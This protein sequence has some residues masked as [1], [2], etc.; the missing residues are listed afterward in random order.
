MVHKVTERDWVGTVV[1]E[2][3][4]TKSTNY[5][6]ISRVSDRLALRLLNMIRLS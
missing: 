3:F 1:I 6:Q 4:I 2:G 5:V